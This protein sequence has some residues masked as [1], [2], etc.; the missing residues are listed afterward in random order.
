MF[1]VFSGGLSHRVEVALPLGL[2]AVGTSPQ[3]LRIEGENLGVGGLVTQLTFL[4]GS[5]T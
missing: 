1:V 2:A 4:G 5:K 3:Q